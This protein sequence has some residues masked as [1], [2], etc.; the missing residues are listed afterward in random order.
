M[1]KQNLMWT[2]LPNGLD[3]NGNLRV[4]AMLS[5]RLTPDADQILKPFTDM[6]D[7]PKTVQAAR[8]TIHFGPQT[9][10][11]RGS[12]TT[13]P[14]KLDAALAVAD[15]SVWTALFHP[16]TFVAG[17]VF[18]DHVGTSVLSYDTV[19]V[20]SL[21]QNLY[22]SIGSKTSD[23]LPKVSALLG[24]SGWQSLVSA[25]SVI[26]RAFGESRNGLR[27][28]Q[29]QFAV[30]KNGGLQ[31]R[32]PVVDALMHA[33][34]FHT[35]PSKPSQQDYTG[36][37][38]D[39][40]DPRRDAKWL[41]FERAKFPGKAEIAKQIDFH[42]IVA[43]MNQYPKLLR[44]LGLVIDFVIPRPSFTD[45]ANQ[46][47]WVTCDFGTD[48]GAGV[49]RIQGS[50]RTRTRRAG[51][52]F[53]PVPRPS[54]AAGD[55]RVRDGLLM[56]NPD[57]FAVLQTDVDAA[58]LKLMNF[59]RTLRKLQASPEHQ[60]DAVTKHEKDTGVPALRNAGLML[61]QR[62]RSQL[63]TNA[64]TANKQKNTAIEQTFAN[65]AIP[66]PD[67]FAEDLIR[68][69]RM[70]VWDRTTAK[71]RSLCERHATYSV[72]GAVNVE[73]DSEGVVRLAATKAADGNNPDIV[74]L[75]E[76][77]ISWTGW[78][79]VA[80][81][82]GLAVDNS[83]TTNNADAEV[84]P[85][86]DLKSAFTAR[87]G[88]LP[89]LRYG[90]SYW[91]RARMVDLA[92][93]SLP[94]NLK[95]YGDE[96]PEKNAV[97]YTR[98]DPVQ[99]PAIT[100]LREG[101]NVEKPL[102]GESME[103]IAIR[104]FNDT[105]PDNTVPTTA[106]A[107][108]FGVPARSSVRDAELHG[109]LDAGGSV[110]GSV[111]TY[112]ML[113]KKDIPLE[114]IKLVTPGPLADPGSTVETS[115]S[116]LNAGTTEIPYLPDPLCT[117]ITAR[118]FDHPGFPD[119]NIIP[120]PAFKG[121]LWPHAQPFTIRI[122]EDAAQVPHFDADTRILQVPLPK[123]IRATL[124]LSCQLAG[125]S[126]D[127]MGIWN[128]IPASSRPA[129][130]KNAQQ[131]QHWMLTPWR[132][133][134]LVHAV[135]RP[136]IAPEMKLVVNRSFGATRAIPRFTATCSIKST[137]RVDLQATWHEPDGDDTGTVGTDRLRNDHAFSVK[138]TDPQFY[139]TIDV[140]PAGGA[141]A[142]HDILGPDLIGVGQNLRHAITKF[143]EL[144]DTRYRR[145][146]YWLE[147]TT[148][149][150][151]F[152][153]ASVLT[154]TKDGNVVET[155]DKIKVTGP[156]AVNWVPNSSPPP[157]PKVLYVVPTFG[158]TTSK[159]AQSETHWR[160]GGGLRVYLDRPW[161]SSGYG[162]MLGVV[163]PPA[164]FA[165]D[166]TTDPAGAPYKHVVTQWGNDPIWSSNF[167]SGTAPK[168]GAFPL[169]RTGP[170]PT[171]N[172]LPSF[173]PATEADQPASPFQTAGLP[174]PGMTSPG[175][176]AELVDVAPHD[177]VYDAERQLWYADLEVNAGSSYY[178]MIRLALAKYQPVSVPG[179]HL[180]SIVLADVMA[181]TPDRWLSISPGSNPT[182]RNVSVFGFTYTDSSGHTEAASAP[183]SIILRQAEN[184]V[185]VAANS[186]VE[187][188]IEKLD[189]ALGEDFGWKRDAGA[190]VTPTPAGPAPRSAPPAVSAPFEEQRA[191]LSIQ[192][193]FSELAQKIDEL[194]PIRLWPQL[195]E[196]SV[197]LPANH[198]PGDRYRLAVAEFEE[199]IVDDA[200]P[201]NK[202]P[203]AKD[204]RIVFLQYVPLT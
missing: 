40:K 97:L 88:S 69:W 46:Q 78:S 83:D 150:R 159:T 89:R 136:L 201:Y 7:W 144:N 121:T 160:R 202:T 92:G 80:Q 101:G 186:V 170:D 153:P 120:I 27:N 82:P 164:S 198:Q 169:A 149:F 28:V 171:G 41:T 90:R 37:P 63:L 122:F 13:A 133:V 58:G 107:R 196:G 172:W 190:S 93:N 154:T 61:V 185:S 146:E 1:A 54:P 86:I 23:A 14:A 5:P 100:L 9:V 131:G 6:L 43:A 96:Q 38:I 156:A 176:S 59:A 79:L 124:R 47:L 132:N 200:T 98:F 117:A 161:N 183:S 180:S 197:T 55:Y 3:T 129:L 18:Q 52:H 71:W 179:A 4:S 39:A 87:K 44:L 118:I 30:F 12:E 103:R 115:Y 109:M 141:L 106:T 184:P 20:H 155:D 135:Q 56:I 163:L 152:M 11:I 70:D 140:N 34:L 94:P 178:P 84:P 114:E 17:Y 123:A 187:V 36:A 182:A 110:D 127:L 85:G 166:P 99:S 15:S 75:H 119:T 73:D 19:A 65:S 143:H 95:S 50:P 16:N 66:G 33:Q 24:D 64:F 175:S 195:W 139:A 111:P 192:R 108:R 60:N 177:V 67:L 48:A 116:V 62:R 68:G 76:A 173:A 191:K 81:Q 104:S 51:G 21:A 147:A 22:S 53:D 130:L 126:L 8:F 102:E 162:E 45:N 49:T 148:R 31:S 57:L 134:E 74:Y 203:S 181:L 105:P 142:E 157:A 128:W 174:H 72:G 193:N 168:L 29:Q 10:V 204:R 165:G 138:I 35:P 189:P 2:A 26:D 158:L 188:W 77:L 137:A 167:V 194:Q 199:Y 42:Q 112:E 113:V 145:I 125:S 32:E 25:V 151:E 91:V